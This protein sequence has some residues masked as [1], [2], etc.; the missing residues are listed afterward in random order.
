MGE[1]LI[2]LLAAPSGAGKS[3]IVKRVLFLLSDLEPIVTY[4]TRKCRPDEVEEVDHHFVTQ[5]EFERMK[6]AGELAESQ[7]I[8]GH[9]Y[10]SLKRR[11]E[12][13]IEQ[14]VDLISDYD[15]VGSETL[16]KLYPDNVVTIFV[17]VPREVLRQRL[18]ERCGGDSREI[19]KREKR[20]D[21]EM[22]CAP[23]FKYEVSNID[24]WEAV[25]NVVSIVRAERCL[26]SRRVLS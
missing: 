17:W 8:F 11:L 24:L 6:S 22:S 15:V 1:G 25:C 12:C 21:M 23:S 9:Q 19:A 13:A 4:T 26:A 16:A 2:F 20:Q 3:T 5:E 7:T 14:G 10:G 18:I